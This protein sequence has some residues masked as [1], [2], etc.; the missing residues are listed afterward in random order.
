M[1]RRAPLT[2]SMPVPTYPSDD[3]DSHAHS[4]RRRTG[5]LAKASGHG[6]PNIQSIITNEASYSGKNKDQF[7][8]NACGSFE[9]PGPTYIDHWGFPIDDVEWTGHGVA[10]AGAE[11]QPG[12]KQN[13]ADIRKNRK[14]STD[15]SMPD[16][17]SMSNLSARTSNRSD[18]Q[19]PVGHYSNDGDLRVRYVRVPANTPTAKDS[20]NC[21]DGT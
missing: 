19:F 14:S 6:M 5:H 18:G 7:P 10:S 11:S 4:P 21:S 9:L 13:T 1:W 12:S 15:T 3:S 20:T 17:I 16:Y 8:Q 2:A